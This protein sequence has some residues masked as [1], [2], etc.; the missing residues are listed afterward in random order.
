[1]PC[2]T[3]ARSANVSST[4]T[5]TVLIYDKDGKELDDEDDKSPELAVDYKEK[6]ITWKW[7]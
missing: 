6:D 1:M 4:S 2:H 7:D 5:G 3:S